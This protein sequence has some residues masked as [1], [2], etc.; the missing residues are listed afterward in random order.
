MIYRIHYNWFYCI[1]FGE[2]YGDF[3][4]G[5]E[6]QLG[7]GSFAVV[8]KIVKNEFSY[9]PDVVDVHFDNGE[10]RI[11]GNLNAILYKD[12]DKPE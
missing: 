4:V 11:Q 6:Y 12:A 1:Q 2:V 7:D 8:T 5:K 10:I 9:R 3:E